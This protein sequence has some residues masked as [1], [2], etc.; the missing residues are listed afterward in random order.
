M[1]QT[2][3]WPEDEMG[4]LTEANL[5]CNLDPDESQQEWEENEVMEMTKDGIEFGF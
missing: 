4:L 2:I 5:D 3:D 1:V